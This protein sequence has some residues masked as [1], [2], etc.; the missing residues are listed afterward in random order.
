MLLSPHGGVGT[1]WQFA[2]MVFGSVVAARSWGER[3]T[4]R[5]R[6]DLRVVQAKRSTRR[7]RRRL[8]RAHPAPAVVPAGART[9]QTFAYVTGKRMLDLALS[10]AGLLVAAPLMGLI[11]LG[12]ALTLGRPILFA[13]QRVGRGGR[14]FRLYKFRTLE[15]RPLE[16]SEVE[17]SAAAPHPLAALLR[18]TGL[19]ELPQLINVLRGEMS[20]VGP[21]PE[22]A[23]FVRQFQ[24]R[25]PRYA[26][27]HRLQAGIT[28]W[29]QVNGF[30]GDTSIARRLEHDLFYLKHWSLG[31]DLWILLLTLGGL[32]MS[33]W[34][35]TRARPLVRQ[36]ELA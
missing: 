5:R 31:F 27:R 6:A 9:T 22:R 8:R 30:R 7:R 1:L 11:A 10:V 33:L 21:R 2:G 24:K 23:H 32:A 20:L 13:Q 17:W 16:L 29:A 4:E 34:K 35:F 19:D 12:I 3:A 14:R 18:H 26:A 15:P 36:A 28:G 25:L